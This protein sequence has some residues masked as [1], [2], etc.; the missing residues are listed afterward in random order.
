MQSRSSCIYSYSSP[1][2]IKQMG[3]G[4][5]GTDNT[6][7]PVLCQYL[8]LYAL[9]KHRNTKFMTFMRINVTCKLLLLTEQNSKY[10]CESITANLSIQC[11][12]LQNSLKG[13]ISLM[14]GI[15][16]WLVSIAAESDIYLTLTQNACMLMC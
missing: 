2:G 10:T 12:N 1:S 4:I 5:I 16:D 8:L 6:E 11:S 15:A 9:Q 3:L 14:T 7:K 13:R